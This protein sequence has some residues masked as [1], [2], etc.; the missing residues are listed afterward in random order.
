MPYR[1]IAPI[2]DVDEGECNYVLIS[3]VTPDGETVTMV[4]AYT[5]RDSPFHADV[6]E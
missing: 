2:V 4:R 3:T 5:L 6:L 1:A